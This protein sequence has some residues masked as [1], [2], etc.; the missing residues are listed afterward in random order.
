MAEL[1]IFSHLPDPRVWKATIAARLCGVEIEVRGAPLWELPGWLWDFDARPLTQ[2]DVEAAQAAEQ[3]G[4]SVVRD[5]FL[6]V[7]D[8][9]LEAM[10]FRGLPAAFSGDGRTGIFQSNSIMR[11]VARLGHERFPLYGRGPYEASRIDGFLDAGLIFAEGV[12]P[13]VSGLHQD[14][15]DFDV[16]RRAYVAAKTYL[17]GINQALKPDRKFLVGGDVTLADICFVSELGVLSAEVTGADALAKSKLEPILGDRAQSNYRRAMGHFR[18]LA[19]HPAFAPDVRPHLEMLEARKPP[20]GRS[21][22]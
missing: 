17:G 5:G 10:P 19:D 1:R 8:A 4:R 15:V 13:Y 21:S 2:A 18:R 3:A 22:G 16:Y 12:E 20:S 7:T 11:A 6:F 14:G 9:Y